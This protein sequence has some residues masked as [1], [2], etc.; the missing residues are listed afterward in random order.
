[1]TTLAAKDLSRQI[2]AKDITLM[3]SI[4]DIAGLNSISRHLI[5]QAAAAICAMSKVENDRDARSLG[6]VA[7]SMFG[8]TTTCVSRCSELLR[9]EGYEVFA[10]HATGIGGKTM[11]SLIMES[12]FDAVLD[13]TTTEL[14]DELCGGICSA[15]PDRLN[16]AAD[17][18]IP[19]VVVPGCLDMVNFAQLDTVPEIYRSRKLYNWAPDVTLMRTN[20]EENKILGRRLAGKL[21]A[22]QAATVIV[23]PNG[24]L[25]QID[26]QGEVF[27]D[28]EA[29][30]ALFEAIRAEARADVEITE[31]DANINDLEF[32]DLL[33]QKLLQLLG[34]RMPNQD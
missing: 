34:R 28:P 2:G 8:N 26:A 5:K 23:L 21:N 20:V 30:K 19:Q 6:R 22:S 3:P 32:A 33:V 15:G 16:A 29:T 10:F 25:S 13:I 24:G 4:V 7:I 12:C 17:K 1:L 14:A 9:K 18:G 11:E 31:V 27:Y